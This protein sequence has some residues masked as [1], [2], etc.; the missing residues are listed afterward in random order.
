VGVSGL[1]LP[2]ALLEVD[3]VAAVATGA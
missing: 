3:V 2:D 1:V